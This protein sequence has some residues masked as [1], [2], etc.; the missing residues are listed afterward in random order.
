MESS[1]AEFMLGD[2]HVKVTGSDEC[3][4]A[5]T[6]MATAKAMSRLR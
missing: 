2:D 3:I 4:D 1:I 5:K 6:E